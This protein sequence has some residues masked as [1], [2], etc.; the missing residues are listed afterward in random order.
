MSDLAFLGWVEA[1]RL[2][3]ERA[4]SPVEYVEALLARIEAHEDAIHAFVALDGDGALD[5]ARAAERERTPRGP[6]HGVPFGLK[7]IIDAAGLP[8]TCHSRILADNVAA[9]DAAVTARLRAAGGILAGKLST[10]EFAIGG[11]GALDLPWPP[12]R[13]PWNAAMVPGGSS[14][15]SGAAVAAGMLPAALGSD[16]GG[17]VRNP[18]SACGIVGMKPTGGRVSRRGVFPLSFSLDNVGPL[19]RTVRENAALLEAIAGHDPRDPASVR[20]EDDGAADFTSALGEGVRGL[21]IGIVRHFH[22]RDATA[23]EDVAAALEA[24][25]GVLEGLGAAVTEVATRPLGEF[26]ACNRTILLCEAFA[27]HE[28][29][30]KE[31]PQDY[32][33]LTRE[34]ILPGAFVQAAD[35]VQAVRERRRLAREYDRLFESVDAVVTVSSM[36]SAIPIDDPDA[37]ARLYSRHARDPANLTA[38][39]ALALPCGFGRAG[40]PVAMQITGRW[41]DEATVYRIAHAYEEAAPWKDRRPQLPGEGARPRSRRAAPAGLPTGGA[42][43]RSGGPRRGGP[44]RAPP[45]TAAARTT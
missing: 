33:A 41:F 3:R 28:R 6:L 21:R 19:T 20:T 1:A 14:S 32:G 4:L 31:R 35:Y 43:G 34:R 29:W 23:D 5:A 10:H 16:T 15:G 44:D 37:I 8:T 9:E 12:A 39:P 13:N 36:Q 42:G 24:A 27:V 2:I 7:D 18:A 40:M 45:G 25:L 26:A 22:T 11:P 30:L 17:S 38:H